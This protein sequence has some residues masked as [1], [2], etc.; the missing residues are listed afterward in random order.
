MDLRVKRISIVS[1]TGTTQR[2]GLVATLYVL[3]AHGVGTSL[4]PMQGV[5]GLR[6]VSGGQRKPQFAQEGFG[7]IGWT[8]LIDIH[9]PIHPP[10]VRG[11]DFAGEGGE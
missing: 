7:D 1:G 11:C 6:S 5:H 3:G 8:A 9:E 2:T 4:L 10:H